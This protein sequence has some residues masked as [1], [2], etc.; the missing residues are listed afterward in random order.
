MDLA[1]RVRAVLRERGRDDLAEI[2]TG[3]GETI[4][5]TREPTRSEWYTVFYI[6]Y[7][8]KGR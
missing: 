1:E 3:T 7:Q 6:A 4:G 5:F 2:V 8:E